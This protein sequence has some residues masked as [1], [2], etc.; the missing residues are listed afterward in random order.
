MKTSFTDE[1]IIQMIKVSAA[2]CDGQT[3][4]LAGKPQEVP[5]DL[6]RRETASAP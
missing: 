5:S 4:G 1:Q 3:A 2:A 6:P